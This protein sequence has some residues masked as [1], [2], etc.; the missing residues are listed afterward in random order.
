MVLNELN[1]KIKAFKQGSMAAQATAPP[2]SKEVI[3]QTE[4]FL[5]E[6]TLAN[7]ALEA[8]FEQSFWD[9]VPMND[10]LFYKKPF[11]TDK[12]EQFFGAYLEDKAMREGEKYE[13]IKKRLLFSIAQLAQHPQKNY[14]YNIMVRFFANGQYPYVIP[15]ID[16]AINPSKMLSPEDV[17]YYDYRKEQVSL[18]GKKAPAI[19]TK[20]ITNFLDQESA[21]KKIL[22]IVGS[23]TPFSQQGL[24]LLHAKTK[25]QKDTKVYAVLLTDNAESVQNFKNLFPSWL[26]HNVANEEANQLAKTY[27]LYYSPTVFLLDRNNVILQEM[28]LYE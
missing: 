12:L 6:P 11:F 19:A 1:S 10:S 21:S 2:Y 17:K 4:L 13:K 14:Y 8:S 26:H 9:N 18:W 16:K 5:Y 27:A 3:K 22:V 23:N 7:E 20:T 28:P 25:E 15:V 24:A